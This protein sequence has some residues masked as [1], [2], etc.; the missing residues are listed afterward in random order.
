MKENGCLLKAY[1][2]N[3]EV[4]VEGGFCHP[5]KGHEVEIVGTETNVPRQSVSVWELHYANVEM[6]KNVFQ[7]CFRCTPEQARDKDK[8]KGVLKTPLKITKKEMALA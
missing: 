4:V 1:F 5:T 6:A 8:K 3:H 7:I 2:G